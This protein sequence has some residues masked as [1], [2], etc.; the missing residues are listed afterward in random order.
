MLCVHA[1]DIPV[2]GQHGHPDFSFLQATPMKFILTIADRASALAAGLASVLLV[3]MVAHTVLEIAL[4]TVGMSTHVLDELVGYELAAMVF[5]GLGQALRQGALIR[6][7]ILLS[8]LRG[9]AR[10]AVEALGA[11]L[12]LLA[13]G[14]LCYYFYLAI[15]RFLARGTLS[16]SVI[17][18]PLWIPNTIIMV[19]L[20]IFGLQLIAYLLRMISGDASI[21]EPSH[22]EVL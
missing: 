9:R 10:R 21:E 6:V 19:G 4:R 22:A 13:V 7:D 8:K 16:N 12:S 2:H 18:V 20:I 15:T 1:R 5:L 11:F 17:A 14:F 3:L